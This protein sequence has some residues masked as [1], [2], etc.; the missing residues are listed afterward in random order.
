MVDAL[1]QGKD[2]LHTACFLV[3]VVKFYSPHPLRLGNVH[4]PRTR[5][6][7]DTLRSGSFMPQ[8]HRLCCS[9]HGTL[10]ET[11]KR[12]LNTTPMGM[13]GMI[14]NTSPTPG[15]EQHTKCTPTKPTDFSESDTPTHKPEP[16]LLTPTHPTGRPKTTLTATQPHPQ[17]N[18]ST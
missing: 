8:S 3:Y 18:K 11:M 7:K 16:N 5:T 12:Q 1:A 4:T 14:I 6:Q 10:T 17:S 15:S 13:I 2:S 9:G